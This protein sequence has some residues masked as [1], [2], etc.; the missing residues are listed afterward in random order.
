MHFHYQEALLWH[1]M[2]GVLDSKAQLLPQQIFRRVTQQ[3][4]L[5]CEHWRDTGTPAMGVHLH[6]SGPFE[7]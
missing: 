5:G 1:I 2:W 6:H 4:E 7:A 3:Q